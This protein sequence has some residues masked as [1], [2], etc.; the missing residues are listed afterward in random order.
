[1]TV[2][3]PAPTMP[4]SGMNQ[5]LRPMFSAA[6]KVIREEVDVGKLEH[7]ADRLAFVRDRVDPRAPGVQ[8]VRRP[9]DRPEEAAGVD[10]GVWVQGELQCGDGSEVA[11]APADRPEEVRLVV[12]VHAEVPP[13]GSHELGREHAVRGE[14][15]SSD[16]PAEASAERVPD[17][18]GV[19]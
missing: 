19:R 7:P 13:V 11:A 10:L 9:L 4:C 12:R 16:H 17:D 14:A 3:M 18:T 8:D 2:V 1:M 6:A 15:V 5:K